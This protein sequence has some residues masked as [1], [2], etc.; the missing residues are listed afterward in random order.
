VATATRAAGLSPAAAL[1]CAPTSDDTTRDTDAQVADMPC[2]RCT[3]GLA[4]A[5]DG[6]A[7]GVGAIASA[8]RDDAR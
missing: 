7:I 5:L 8:R 1:A 2:S 4:T 3:R 6:A